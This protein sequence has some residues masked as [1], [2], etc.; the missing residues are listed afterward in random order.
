MSADCTAA[1][2]WLSTF[3]D[4]DAVH[5][6]T[7]RAHI[8]DC[9]A[10]TTWEATVDTVTR[11]MAVRSA[12]SP[13]L[14]APAMAA[15]RAPE[16]AG[17]NRLGRMLLAVAGVA[18]LVLA[19]V[20]MAGSPALHPA[21]DVVAFEAALSVG[22]LL[23]AW[24]PEVYGRSLLPVAGVAALLVLVPTA[25]DVGRT[26]NLAAEASHLAVLLGLAGLFAQADA[27]RHSARRAPGHR[28][29]RAA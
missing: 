26:T 11:R 8:D 21:R 18:G 9:A 10:C 25:A 19:A 4:G 27:S 6:A 1:R 20:S 16:R 29:A 13:D 15:W 7:A 23:A 24:R 17:E 14:V 3:R 28:G 2:R 22:F 12:G 5:D